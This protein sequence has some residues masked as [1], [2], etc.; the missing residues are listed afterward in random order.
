MR[1]LI[2]HFLQSWKFENFCGQKS[3][4][5]GCAVLLKNTALACA[6]PACDSHLS[7]TSENAVPI[8]FHLRALYCLNE[9]CGN[10]S[11]EVTLLPGINC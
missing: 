6:P 1:G 9:N 8:H 4:Y 2:G 11:N 5:Y 7:G 3:P 10:I